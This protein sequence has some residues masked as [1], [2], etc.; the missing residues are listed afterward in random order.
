MISRRQ[1]LIAVAG[2]AGCALAPEG[3]AFASEPWKIS[4]GR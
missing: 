2:A 3:I 4:K 1:M